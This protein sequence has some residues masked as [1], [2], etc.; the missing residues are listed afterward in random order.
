MGFT[1]GG[2]TYHLA[3]TTTPDFVIGKTLIENP[4]TK[5]AISISDSEYV[6]KTRKKYANI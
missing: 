3:E 6:Q 5:K 2:K 4:Y 1:Y